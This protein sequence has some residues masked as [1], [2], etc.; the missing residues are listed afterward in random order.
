MVLQV[1]K[2]KRSILLL[3]AVLLMMVYGRYS[4]SAAASVISVEADRTE[5]QPGDVITF[6]VVLGPAEALGT[7]QMVLD[8]PD[9]LTYIPGS[10]KLEEGLVKT[11]GFDQAAFTEARLLIN[12]IASRA[13]YSS[14]TDTLLCTFQCRVDEDFTGTISVGLKN[15]EFF[16]CITWEDHTSEYRVDE[17]YIHASRA[18]PAPASEIPSQ[19]AA[20]EEYTETGKTQVSGENTAAGNE[21]GGT[22]IKPAPGAANEIPVA[23]S[24]SKS[25]QK[26][27]MKLERNS[28]RPAKR[29][30][31]DRK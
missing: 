11:L 18:D 7:M 10:G 24:V 29:A 6:S 12:G 1:Q 28:P 23:V 2:R 13:D 20:A 21:P 8:I 31:I 16:S 25:L 14:N 3:A 26:K 22:T 19:S 5:V 27:R 9:G 17:A 30:G 15:L 4:V